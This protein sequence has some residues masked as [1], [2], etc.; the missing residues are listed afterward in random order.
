MNRREVKQRF[1]KALEELTGA[2]VAIKEPTFSDIVN[3]IVLPRGKFLLSQEGL[4]RALLCCDRDVVTPSFFKY[5]FSCELIKDIGQFEAGV[6]RFREKAM[7]LYGNLEFAFRE[8]RQ[9]EDLPKFLREQRCEPL[10]ESEIRRDTPFGLQKIEKSHRWTL[11]HITYDDE[12]QKLEEQKASGRL[13]EVEFQKRKAEYDAV[14]KRTRARG[15]RNLRKYLTLD[16][17]DVYVATSMRGRD[18][19]EEMA[20]FVEAVFEKDPI[21]PLNLRYFDPTQSY[22]EDRIS[23]G[24]LECFLLKRAKV[25]IYHA[26]YSDT[27]GKDSELAITLAQGKPVIVYVPKKWRLKNEVGADMLDKRYE[28]FKETHPLGLQVDLKTGVAH[29]VIVVRDVR[30]CADILKKV[31]LNRLETEIVIEGENLV[32]REKETGSVL[33]VVSQNKVLSR[34]FW[35]YYLRR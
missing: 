6:G 4:N 5:F 24:L 28:I 8:F 16:D 9:Q 25:T 32:L 22:I 21:R 3:D 11:G 18:D 26:G 23:A 29:G 35:N 19:Y 33:R 14:A 7:L 12:I 15:K 27:L 30:Q 2:P 17:L 13:S 34:T 10:D 20:D 31:L 1:Y